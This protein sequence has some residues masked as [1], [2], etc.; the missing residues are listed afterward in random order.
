M[1]KWVARPMQQRE[2]CPCTPF[3]SMA[4]SQGSTRYLRPES[5]RLRFVSFMNRPGAEFK[6]NQVKSSERVSEK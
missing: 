3:R 1:L 4:G 6:S 5:V 2:P